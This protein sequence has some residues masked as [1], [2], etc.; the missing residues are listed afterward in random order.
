MREIETKLTILRRL[1]DIA[2]E[3]SPPMLHPRL[4]YRVKNLAFGSKEVD[5][6]FEGDGGKK[7]VAHV[8]ESRRCPTDVDQSRNESRPIQGIFPLVSD[9]GVKAAVPALLVH[10]VQLDVPLERVER[11]VPR[12]ERSIR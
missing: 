1:F 4:P 11:L 6:D 10:G 8:A 2:I 5:E 12:L 3:L 9:D 7:S